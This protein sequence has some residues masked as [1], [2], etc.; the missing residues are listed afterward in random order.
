MSGDED[1]DKWIEAASDDGW[2]PTADGW[3]PSEFDDLETGPPL[4]ID[5]LKTAR[6][7]LARWRSP[8][9]FRLAVQ[10][11]HKR[12]RSWE[13]KGPER[14][15]LLDAWTLAEFVGH[16]SVDQVRLAD[17][18]EQWPDG[19]VKIGQRVEN[20]EVTIALMPGRR[21]WDEYERGAKFVVED[22]PVED[23]VARVRRYPCRA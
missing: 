2:D 9:D 3:G 10:R 4:S 15:F 21:M 16:K 20:V 6:A 12:C 14:T 23:W 19:Y 11:L 1:M 13:F 8:A 22:D 5:E 17:A 18:S 7:D